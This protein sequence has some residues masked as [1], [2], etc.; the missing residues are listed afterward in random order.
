M[1]VIDSG[2]WRKRRQASPC[3]FCRH[4][5]FFVG[6]ILTPLCMRVDTSIKA[7][8]QSN[9]ASEQGAASNT[10]LNAWML[11]ASVATVAAFYL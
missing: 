6:N 10:M 4:D 2:E 9:G 3:A 5:L 8:G 7:T 11:A 1:V